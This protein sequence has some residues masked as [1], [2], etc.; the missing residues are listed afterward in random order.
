MIKYPEQLPAILLSGYSIE[1][2]DST[3]RTPMSSGRERVRRRFES[4]PEYPQGSVLMTPN[5]AAFFRS[6]V[7]A[8]TLRGEPLVY[9]PLEDA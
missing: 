9:L 6:L 2:I 4:V 8:S 1:Q 3:V 5:Q 7:R